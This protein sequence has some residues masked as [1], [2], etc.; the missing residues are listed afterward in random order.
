MLCY[1]CHAVNNCPKK[2]VW[3][4]NLPWLVLVLT[5]A[6]DTFTNFALFHGIYWGKVPIVNE[7]A[8]LVV[9]IAIYW[10]GFAD[11]YWICD[12]DTKQLDTKLSKLSSVFSLASAHCVRKG[13]KKRWHPFSRTNVQY[14]FPSMTDS[15][16]ISLPSNINCCV[17]CECHFLF[18]YLSMQIKRSRTELLE[19]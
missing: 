14:K 11:Q 16:N 17:A 15:Q 7:A 9:V 4:G 13:T 18:F 3:F 6:H 19:Q 2:Y 12:L 10:W 8:L 1:I 5:T